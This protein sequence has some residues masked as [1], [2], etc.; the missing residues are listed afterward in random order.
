MT[1]RRCA[2]CRWHDLA[3][4]FSDLADPPEDQLGLCTWPAERLPYSLR[5]G[6]RE[7]AATTSL[8]GVDCP[9]WEAKA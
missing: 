2:T 7:R 6:N 1:E 8:E 5:W 3:A 9:A 4:L